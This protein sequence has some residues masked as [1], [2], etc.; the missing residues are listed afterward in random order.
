[1]VPVGLSSKLK[2]ICSSLGRFWWFLGCELWPVKGRRYFE[3]N[4]EL[5]SNIATDKHH[6]RCIQQIYI[7]LGLGIL[8]S[9]V[10]SVYDSPLFMLLTFDYPGYSRLPISTKIFKTLLNITAGY[11]YHT[12]YFCIGNL[13]KFAKFN[14]ILTHDDRTL[15]LGSTY[16]F[17]RIIQAGLSFY[18]VFVFGVELGMFLCYL[19]FFVVLWSHDF[20]SLWL[21][22]LAYLSMSIGFFFFG[23]TIL[24]L[25]VGGF[26]G[27]FVLFAIIVLFERLRMQKCR[28]LN[29][30]I[31]RFT[32]TRLQ[33]YRRA[34][35]TTMRLLS[36]KS[37][38]YGSLLLNYLWTNLPFNVSLVSL[39]ILNK[40]LTIVSIGI[41]ILTASCK[42]CP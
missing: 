13:T 12:L 25:C 4:I 18:Q 28:Y 30:P 9:I 41:G 5:I 8:L 37:K 32:V 21:H 2:G 10:Q 3:E 6:G 29:R 27:A 7:L 14:D 17:W 16:N 20:G 11:F 26:A 40:G 1:M 23:L 36:L 19:Q 39:L 38:L 22:L 31:D 33:R 15:V 34:N 42:S 24:L 35:V